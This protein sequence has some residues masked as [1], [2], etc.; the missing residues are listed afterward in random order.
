V[1]PAGTVRLL[2]LAAVSTAALG[3]TAPPGRP[4]SFREEARVER[5]I[6]D[7][8]VTDWHGDPIPEL[9]PADFRLRVD[10]R[11]LDLESADW[12]GDS[13]SCWSQRSPPR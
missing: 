1:K 12:I 11:P 13:L 3:Q 9:G 5:V 10:G 4:G 8:Y 7:A 6:V 2:A